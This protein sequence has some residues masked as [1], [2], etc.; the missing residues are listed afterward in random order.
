LLYG[1]DL[2]RLVPW[3]TQPLD[4]RTVEGTSVTEVDML[5]NSMVFDGTLPLLPFDHAA[6]DFL[7]TVSGASGTAPAVLALV[8]EA[9]GTLIYLNTVGYQTACSAHF[10]RLWQ[11]EPLA[12][13]PKL[14]VGWDSQMCIIRHKEWSYQEIGGPLKETPFVNA[15]GLTRLANIDYGMKVPPLFPTEE[16]PTTAPAA[17]DDEDQVEEPP[18]AA[19]AKVNLSAAP[20]RFIF[21]NHHETT[22]AVL[23][24][25]GHLRTLRVV[26]LYDTRSSDH[27]RCTQTWLEQLWLHGLEAQLI[28]PL[29][30]LGIRAWRLTGDLL[31]WADLIQTGLSSAWLP[32][33]A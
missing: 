7:G 33:P 21:G 11:N 10:A 18:P 32:R 23:A 22:P 24:F 3:L 16:L 29:P 25:H 20:P 30:A 14:G 4:L 8:T 12:F 2:A 15:M 13:Q 28:V 31:A 19:Q 1:L 6:G 26:R 5:R 17:T 27:Q 9:D